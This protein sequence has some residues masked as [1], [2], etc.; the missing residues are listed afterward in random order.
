MTVP[1]GHVRFT[2]QDTGESV[3]MRLGAEPAKYKAAVGGWQTQP[4]PYSD[5]A[6]YWRAPQ[7]PR[8]LVISV[9]AEGFMKASIEDDWRALE[10]MG[11]A[12]AREDG[13]DAAPPRIRVEGMVPGARHVWVMADLE[14]GTPVWLGGRA[15][16]RRCRQEGT[17]TLIR[18]RE[19]PAVRTQKRISA[20]GQSGKAKTRTVRASAHD[21]LQKVALREL[22]NA[23]RWDEIYEINRRVVK[24]KKK[25]APFPRDPRRL[26]KAGT[27][28]KLPRR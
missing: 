4:L 20:R 19:N 2:R 18:P 21:T 28:V 17:V 3:T 23:S 25:D 24:G 12:D 27:T 26:L 11:E 15:G 9:M 5:P 6:T 8:Q 1:D 16:P 13:E 10:E 22:G 14:E 7:D